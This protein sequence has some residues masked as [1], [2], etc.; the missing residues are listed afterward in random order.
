M[1]LY[2]MLRIINPLRVVNN[3][4]LKFGESANN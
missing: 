4:T 3:I 1:R 2:S